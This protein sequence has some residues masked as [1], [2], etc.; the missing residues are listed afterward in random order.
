[1]FGIETPMGRTPFQGA[2]LDVASPRAKAPDF[3]RPTSQLAFWLHTPQHEG[4][5]SLAAAAWAILLDRS[6]VIG[7][8]PNSCGRRKRLLSRCRA[9]RENRTRPLTRTR[10]R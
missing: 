4:R 1:M 2:S 6:A 3:A 9:I 10:P 8:C 7:K 5:H